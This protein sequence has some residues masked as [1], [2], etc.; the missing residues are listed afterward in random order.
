[1]KIYNI[2]LV[3]VFFIGHAAFSQCSPDY[4]YSPPFANYG[5]SPDTLPSGVVYEDYNE[6]LT[7]FLPVDTLYDLGFP[8]N[9]VNV[10]FVDY[11]ITAISLPLGLS[12]ECNNQDLDCHYDPSQS[13]YGCVNI[14]GQP[15]QQGLFD[16]EVTVLANHQFSST[17]G[18]EIISFSLPLYI[19]PNAAQNDGFSMTNYSGCAP[20]I[21]DFINNQSNM[22]AF[23]WDFG[24]GSMSL[25][26]NP[27]TQMYYD[28]GVYEVT[29][30]VYPTTEPSNF[31][32]T[33]VIEAA[34]GWGSDLEDLFTSPDPYFKIFD[35]Q[36]NEVYQSVFVENQD[37][38]VSFNVG[39]LLLGDGN[40]FIDVYDD[41][42]SF[43][44]DDDYLGSVSFSVSS[45]SGTLNDGDLIVSYVIYEE[46][47]EPLLYTDFVYVYEYPQQPVFEFV[48]ESQSLVLNSDSAD[49]VYQWFIDEQ[50]IINENNTFIYPNL[51]G[52]YS[53]S[54]NNNGCVSFSSDT[55]LIHCLD[56]YVCEIQLDN[57]MFSC[58]NEMDLDCQWFHNGSPISGANSDELT[59]TESG[60]YSLELSDEYGCVYK[61][62][63]MNFTLASLYNLQTTNIKLFP[64]PSSS[65]VNITLDNQNGS[66]VTIVVND[67]RG[68]ELIRNQFHSNSYQFDV[69]QFKSGVYSLVVQL[70]GSTQSFR[71]VVN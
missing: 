8:I 3:A 66:V 30:Q 57:G 2:I 5:L 63:E 9:E 1:M 12:W 60:L 28:P 58:S 40:Y 54:A 53:L 17:S 61:S 71:L 16:V 20:L 4:T 55:F 21:V 56:N 31:L 34:S 68:R 62:E 33:V 50:V 51:T 38:P 25:M 39:N 70:D 29:L 24:N 23:N 41:D 27:S 69:S 7:F 13:Q 64:N 45:S 26:D 37:F 43:A 35:D 42:G 14:Y 65:I 36:G 52:N 49:V 18:P 10:V 59:A 11:H 67:L 19:G 32:Q 47:P 15:M 44:G 6:D 22:S 46:M 48:E